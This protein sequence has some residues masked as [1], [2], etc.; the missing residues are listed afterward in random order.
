MENIFT[1]K[2]PTDNIQENL[3]DIRLNSGIN[4]QKLENEYY[5]LNED[6]D[7][8]QLNQD[9]R[10]SYYKRVKP[11]FLEKTFNKNFKS[12]SMKSKS[13]FYNDDK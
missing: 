11:N 9:N 3:K 4:F 6:E 2:A 10:G 1:N 5:D 12:S 13:K 7:E 8:T